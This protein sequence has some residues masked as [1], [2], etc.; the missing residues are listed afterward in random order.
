MIKKIDTILN[1]ILVAL[2]LVAAG[3][4]FFTETIIAIV[5]V[6]IFVAAIVVRMIINKKDSNIIK[7]KRKG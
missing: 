2:L 6:G 7:F 5:W 3:I 4:G 1:W